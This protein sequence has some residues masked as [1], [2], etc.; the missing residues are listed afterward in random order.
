MVTW[1]IE[2][3]ALQA[4][5]ICLC[6]CIIEILLGKSEEREGMKEWEAAHYTK[7]TFIAFQNLYLVSRQCMSR[8]SSD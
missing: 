4:D 1:L 8:A 7:L 3:D 2:E 6:I 5:H